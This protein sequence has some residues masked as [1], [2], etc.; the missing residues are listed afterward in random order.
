[1]RTHTIKTRSQTNSRVLCFAHVLA[2]TIML[3]A[4]GTQE[5]FGQQ[6]RMTVDAGATFAPSVNATFGYNGSFVG[7]F[8]AGDATRTCRTI[9]GLFGGNTN[10]PNNQR[11]TLNQRSGSAVGTGNTVPTGTLTVRVNPA[12]RTVELFNVNTN[13]IGASTPPSA[14][15]NLTL[16]YAA[17]RTFSP[18]Y[19]YL[20]LGDLNLPLGNASLT[21]LTAVQSGRAFA[22]ATPGANPG[23]LNFSIPVPVLLSATVNFQGTEL[24]AQLPQTLTINGTFNLGS[25]T[26]FVTL[27]VALDATNQIAPVLGDINNPTPFAL[28]AASTV[29]DSPPAPVLLTLNVTGGSVS[30][31]GNLAAAARGQQGNIADIGSQGG[32]VGP[33]GRLDSN[34]FVVFVDRFFALDAIADV[35]SQ[36]GLIGADAAYD[37]ND[38]VA[39]VSAFFAS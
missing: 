35:G 33:D 37:S 6:F 30:I 34:D 7:D 2:G 1:M 8:V 39:F 4:S 19:L 22:I 32:A 15:V 5:T 20:S 9:T 13:L 38:F 26:S 12:T 17:F 11:I 23:Q 16:N 21:T 27:S 25:A 28:P 36:G 14:A 29:P 24:P 10:P 3:G 31:N 18:N